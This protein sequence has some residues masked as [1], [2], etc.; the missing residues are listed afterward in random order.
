MKARVISD[1]GDRWSVKLVI[2]TL[3]FVDERLLWLAEF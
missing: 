3:L 1:S 2:W